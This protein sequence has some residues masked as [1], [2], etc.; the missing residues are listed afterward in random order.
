MTPNICS[1]SWNSSPPVRSEDFLSK[2]SP[3][4]PTE[5]QE[6]LPIELTGTRGAVLELIRLGAQQGRPATIRE[7]AAKLGLSSPASV[8]RHLRR[9]EQTGW[10]TRDPLSG[11]RG[12]RPV[13]G[14]D[15]AQNNAIPIVGRIAAGQPIESCTD[16]GH[17]PHEWLEITP[18]AFGGT[19]SVVALKVE[20]MSMQEA[21]ILSGDLAIV[22]RQ[23]TVENG[24]IAAVTIDGEGTLKTWRLETS[25]SH[26]AA[27]QAGPNR[28][29]TKK[30]TA[31]SRVRLEA[32][33]S[34]FDDIELDPTKVPIEVFGK[35]IGVVRQFQRR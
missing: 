18:Q 35:L 3:P 29:G 34:E 22:R 26:S 20:G 15:P 25:L 31:R 4:H 2:K 14:A 1:P 32:A 16:G 17:Q 23:P 27:N 11:S 5:S 19:S 9:L 12:W 10:I 7:I 8:H 13:P 28:S 30:Q 6:S 24:E 33:N 21:G